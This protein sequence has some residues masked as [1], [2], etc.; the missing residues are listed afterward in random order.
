MEKEISEMTTG[1]VMKMLCSEIDVY[2]KVEQNL[3]RLILEEKPEAI[4]PMLSREI[5]ET[6]ASGSSQYMPSCIEEFMK[7]GT[8]LNDKQ[9]ES[10]ASEVDEVAG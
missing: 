7:S 4:L 9:E 8:H 5:E 2:D 1:E 3:R 10:E 6:T